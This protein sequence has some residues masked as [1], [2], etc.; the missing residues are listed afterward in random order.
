V[1]LGTQR[2]AEKMLVLARQALGETKGRAYRSGGVRRSH[3]T[4]Q[5]ERWLREGLVAAGL[6]EDDLAGLP[7]SDPRKVA[8]AELLSRGTTVTQPWIAE[9]LQMRS[10]ANVSQQLRRGL[11]RSGKSLP[12]ALRYF[13]RKHTVSRFEP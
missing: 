9:R 11:P 3:D 10:A 1:V 6:V 8:L 2:F 5:A 7:G 4:H 12:T 13:L